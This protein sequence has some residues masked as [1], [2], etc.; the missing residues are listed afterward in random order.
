MSYDDL[1][2]CLECGDYFRE[3]DTGGY[4]PECRC[5]KEWCVSL[6]RTCCDAIESRQ[7]PEDDEEMRPEE[8]R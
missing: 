1:P 2:F 7:D 3:D 5:G 4:N 6:C 8:T